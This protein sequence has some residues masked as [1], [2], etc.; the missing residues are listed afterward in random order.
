MAIDPNK[1]LLIKY[2]IG[3]CT[4][5]E[6]TH[7]EAY[8]RNE[9]NTALV[10]E[11]LME[12]SLTKGKEDTFEGLSDA[13]LRAY[14]NRFVDLSEQGVATKAKNKYRTNRNALVLWSSVAAACLLMVWLFR[15]SDLYSHF[16]G[17]DPMR[18]YQAATDIPVSKYIL[19]D[20]SV[21]WLT[22]GSIVEMDNDFGTSNRK[23]RLRTGEA[24]FDVKRNESLHFIVH[25]EHLTTKVLGTAFLISDDP[26]LNI[27]NVQITRGKV[28]VESGGRLFTNLT[29]GK[30][31]TYYKNTN[32]ADS[33]HY[34]K[35]LFNPEKQSLFVDDISFE[36]LTFRVKQVYGYD[37]HS[38]SE[39]IKAGRFTL[40]LDFDKGIAQV[41]ENLAWIYNCTYQIKGK[42]VW[43]R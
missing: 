26:H 21:M 38:D 29:A 9:D 3:R 23:V 22:A 27:A 18:N 13:D 41:I 8:I 20:S 5:E 43:M 15:G 11:V 2:F 32:T 1:E 36:E 6:E 42:E 24:Y 25:S 34:D 28:E 16:I 33:S 12:L 35:I 4:T 39:L 10:D 19:P 40:E 14:W 7:V 37:L 30:A 17:Q 31:V